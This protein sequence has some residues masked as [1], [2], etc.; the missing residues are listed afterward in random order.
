MAS[1]RMVV[2]DLYLRH[3]PVSIDTV[4]PDYSKAYISH[5]WTYDAVSLLSARQREQANLADDGK[6]YHIIEPATAID[7]RQYRWGKA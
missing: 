3:I 4:K 1:D 2:T 6:D 5:Q 7:Y